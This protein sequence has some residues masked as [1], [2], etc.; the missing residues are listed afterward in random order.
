MP[1][2]EH[3]AISA[4]GFPI[5]YDV[6]G[7]GVP[8]LVFVHGWCCDRHYWDGQVRYFAPRYTVVCLDLAGHGASGHDRTQWTVPAFGQD[9]V[10]V[11]EQLGLEQVVLIGHSIGGQWIIEAAR[12]LP[13]SVIGVV[14]ADARAWQSVEDTLTP[15]QVAETMAPFRAHFL[16]AMRTFVQGTFVSTSEPTLV[17]HVIRG[18]SAAPPHIA[19]DVREEGLGN[20]RNL[21]AGLQEVTAPKIAINAES[22]HPTNMTAMQRYGIEVVQMSEVGHFVML[23]DPQ[24]FNRLLDE[25][26]QKCIHARARQ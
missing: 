26:V 23:E 12:H 4:D 18:M 6:H 8:A 17:E 13:R 15:A 11:V 10:A 22:W 24:T 25:A 3:V 21:Q 20:S 16:E 2:Q 14:G 19:I 5:H 9:I 7:T 1:T